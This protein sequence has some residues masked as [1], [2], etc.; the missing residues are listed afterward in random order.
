[1]ILPSISKGGG[2]GAENVL[3][4]QE[5]PWSQNYILVGTGSKKSRVSYDSLSMNYWVSGFAQIIRINL[6]WLILK[7]CL[8]IY[9]TSWRT[10]IALAGKQPKDAI[11]ALLCE[12]IAN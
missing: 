10:A 5:I 9:L 11:A 8:S 4:K 12:W 1:M 3:F 6:P 2:G 7:V